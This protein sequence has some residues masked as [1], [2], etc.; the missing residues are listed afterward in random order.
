MKKQIVRISVLQ[1]S[2]V[3]ALLY[4]LIG[5]LYTAVGI[6]L[7]FTATN[8][9]ERI[10]ACVFITAPIWTALA[11]FV[12]FAI[13]AAVYNLAARWIGGFEL[14]VADVEADDDDELEVTP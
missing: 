13:A 14:E 12:F 6:G 8:P 2:K 10:L 11:G 7:L 5:F 4:S 3:A 1:S 9:E